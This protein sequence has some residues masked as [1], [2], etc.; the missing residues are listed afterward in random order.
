MVRPSIYWKTILPLSTW[1]RSRYSRTLRASAEM[2]GPMPSPPRMPMRTGLTWE[3][4]VHSWSCLRRSTRSSCSL[5]MVAKWEVALVMIWVSATGPPRLG[6]GQLYEGVGYSANGMGE[7]MGSRFRGNCWR[8]DDGKDVGAQEGRIFEGGGPWDKRVVRARGGGWVPA[9]ARTTE[10]RRGG[11]HPHPR[12]KGG[13]S[14]RVPASARTTGDGRAVREPP[15]R[16]ADD[17]E[18]TG[19]G[20]CIS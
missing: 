9:S 12:G 6:M 7:G 10:R 14:G 17:M 18:S 20:Q 5:S 1:S 13:E 2:A 19:V 8:G 15:P 3:K 16:V 11:L 4:S